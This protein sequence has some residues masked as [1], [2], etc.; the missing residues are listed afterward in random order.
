MTSIL[1]H[2]FFCGDI[3]LHS[4]LEVGPSVFSRRS[5]LSIIQKSIVFPY[6]TYLSCFSFVQHTITKN[7][8]SIYDTTFENIHNVNYTL[9]EWVYNVSLWG[10]Y[11]FFLL[12]GS[13]FVWGNIWYI[14]LRGYILLYWS[15]YIFWEVVYTIVLTKRAYTFFCEWSSTYFNSLRG[16]ILNFCEWV[17]IY[18]F[19]VRVCTIYSVDRV[20]T[21]FC[22]WVYTS[23]FWEGIYF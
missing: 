15:Q 6:T 1:L 14:L 19:F 8:T 3:L 16:Y 20:Y 7:S 18:C 13:T 21:S 4:S 23:F 9:F 17:S 5:I 12:R 10:V 11:T 22:E 2:S